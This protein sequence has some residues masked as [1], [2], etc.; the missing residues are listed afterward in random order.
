MV[1]M[2]EHYDRRL[3]FKQAGA[4]GLSAA[5]L[6]AFLAAC[7]STTSTTTTASSV[8]L[9]GPIAIGTLL[10]KAKKEGKLEAIGIPPEWADY[11]DILNTYTSKYV[12]VQYQAEAE[13]SSAQ[14]LEVFKKS[15]LHPHGDIGDVGF[16]FGPQ[17][18]QQGLVTP[19]KHSKWDDIP[20]ELKDPKGNW[21]TE[22]WGAQAFV[23]NT[24]LV[25]NEPASFKDLLNGDYKNMVGIDGDPREANDAFIAVY[26]A[27]LATSGSLDSIQPG[28]DF[29]AQLKK[30]GNFTAARSSVANVTKG[31]VAIAIMW[32]YLGLGFRDQLKG[33]P[34]L[35]VIIPSDGS[36][37]GPYVSIINKTA[38]DPYAA[39]LWMEYIFSDE[40]QLN[41]LK[42]YAHPA[43]YQSLVK[44]GKIPAELAAKLPPAE[45]Y[46]N[47]KFVTDL[48]KLD[49]A[50]TALSNNWQS[51]V[52]GQ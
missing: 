5:S 16:K 12:K 44:A 33:K 32:D 48:G 51:Q 37:A 39:R 11:K 9:A 7:G 21:C 52:L 46:A 36:I 31:E 43:R 13:F 4:L 10:E 38:P 50:A 47:V 35:K 49:A 28:I 45:Q 24:D 42:G 6:S 29:F 30:K 25:K 20:A 40:G 17:A 22:Y 15:K 1:D 23:I 26:S 34:N 27:A 41:Y 14:E 8:D 19:Y 3:F 2:N 18:V